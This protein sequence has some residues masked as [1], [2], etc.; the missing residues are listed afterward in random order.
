LTSNTGS[1]TGSKTSDHDRSE[2]HTVVI[3]GANRGIGLALVGLYRARGCRVYAICR[4]ASTALQALNVTIIDGVEVTQSSGRAALLA[5]LDGVSIDL[6]INNAGILR[7]ETLGSI[8]AES[9]RQQFEVNALAPLLITE[10]LRGQLA[11]NA[12]VALVTSRMGSIADNGSGAYYGYRMSKAALNMAGKSLALDLQ[13]QGV[14]VVIL[15]PGM[16]A[17]DMIGGRGD[18]TAEVA[19]DGLAARIDEVTLDTSGR[20]VHASGEALPW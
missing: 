12:K 17:T 14:A 13:P 11:A 18:V 4:Q 20:F 15:H 19:A 8:D 3:T 5:G 9:V 6:L 2:H 7:S 1:K 10:A 16:V